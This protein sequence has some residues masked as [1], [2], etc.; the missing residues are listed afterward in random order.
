MWCDVTL[1]SSLCDKAQQIH[2]FSSTLFHL[3]L[4]ALKLQKVE[5]WRFR[6]SV[7]W[8]CN[9][10][11]SRVD[12]CRVFVVVT[13]SAANERSQSDLCCVSLHRPVR[14]HQQPVFHKL[15]D[16]ISFSNRVFFLGL[17]CLCPR[18]KEYPIV[19]PDLTSPFKQLWC[20]FHCRQFCWSEKH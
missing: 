12:S 2:Y 13:I 17:F 6:Y 5:T 19:V 3:S 10:F 9:M 4:W 16:P 7:C 15:Y 20:C 11:R 14:S 8:G 18:W 1:Q